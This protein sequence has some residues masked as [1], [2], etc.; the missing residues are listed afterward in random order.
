MLGNMAK[1]PGGLARERL[2]ASP[3]SQHGV[4]PFLSVEPLCHGYLEKDGPPRE[5]GWS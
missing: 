5:V 2:Q 4:S 1:G 3:R